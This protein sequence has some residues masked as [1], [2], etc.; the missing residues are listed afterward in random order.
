MSIADLL[1]TTILM[2]S[3]GSMTELPASNIGADIGKV[4]KSDWEKKGTNIGNVED[5]YITVSGKSSVLIKKIQGITGFSMTRENQQRHTGG[6]S[7]Y[8][9]NLPGM[10][11]YSDV[12][13]A[14]TF[15]RDKFFLDWLKNGYL[16]GGVYR[17]NIEI[18]ILP[19]G[20][21]E[22][23]FTLEDAF[24]VSWDIVRM[25]VNNNS[26]PLMELV[27]LTYSKL[28]FTKQNKSS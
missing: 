21:T 15:T 9:V 22:M 14:H 5:T 24:P 11:S 28:T 8:V 6:I 18:H 17:A 3:G 25:E 4:V 19:L 23:V 27:T 7:D 13:L 12:T 1:T 2:P 26:D 16:I 10:V 20:T